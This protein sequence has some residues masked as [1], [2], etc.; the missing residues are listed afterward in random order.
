VAWIL[1]AINVNQIIQEKSALCLMPWKPYRRGE[2][3]WWWVHDLWIWFG[4]W[5]SLGKSL[6]I[7]F[8][9]VL[10]LHCS[11]SLVPLM[12]YLFR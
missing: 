3:D 2:Q 8:S 11:A 10:S 12:P 7:C 6:H 1:Y 4:H 9:S 5:I